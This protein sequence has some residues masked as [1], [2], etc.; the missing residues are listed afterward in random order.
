MQKHIEHMYLLFLLLD[1]YRKNGFSSLRIT[2]IA[3]IIYGAQTNYHQDD[4]EGKLSYQYIGKT[5]NIFN[6]GCDSRAKQ[7]S[8]GSYIGPNKALPTKE[9]V[10]LNCVLFQKRFKKSTDS[11]N[12]MSSYIEVHFSYLKIKG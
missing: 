12:I 7:Y 5:W 6:S 8:D 4:I 1:G 3:T 2:N 9:Q 11:T 10:T